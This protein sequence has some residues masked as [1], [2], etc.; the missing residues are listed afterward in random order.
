MHFRTTTTAA[1]I[2]TLLAALLLTGCT[3]SGG[4]DPLPR[5]T[6]HAAPSA[7]ATPKADGGTDDAD[8]TQE[9]VSAEQAVA[10]GTVVAETDVVSPSGKT[11]VHVR[12]V[13]NDRGTFDARLSGYRTTEPQ[14]MSLE[15]RSG[16]A[17]PGDGYDG[18]AVD[19]VAWT[20]GEQPPATVSMSDAGVSPDWLQS[21]VL[22]PTPSEDGDDADRPWVGSV[23]AAGKLTWTL[24]NPYPGL[25]A[26]LGPAR[27]GAYGYAFGADGK[28]LLGTTGTPVR[29]R[30]Q[31]GDDLT[32][33]VER[34]GLTAEQIQW[35]NPR[36]RLGG[37][38]LIA[39]VD[40]NLD[41]A[42]R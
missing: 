42:T 33:V 7:S 35:L 36:L 9:T 23:L 25:H 3:A 10:T 28:A 37:D 4:D 27:P 6:G 40:L 19:R 1:A 38:E 24:P 11:A 2:G 14:P 32:T 17:E 12:I 13:A 20:A 41:P 16:S 15:F 8:G 30:V 5:P 29:Y 39:A 26:T 18:A 34:F 31:E 22:V 21:V